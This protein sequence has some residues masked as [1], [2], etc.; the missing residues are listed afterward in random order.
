MLLLLEGF[1]LRHL[2]KFGRII[3][4]S[5]CKIRVLIIAVDLVVVFLSTTII[6]SKISFFDKFKITLI[7]SI[8]EYVDVE[9]LLNQIPFEGLNENEIIGLKN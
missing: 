1:G 8:N 3:K 5:F 6:I 4:L 2:L 9:D 7:V